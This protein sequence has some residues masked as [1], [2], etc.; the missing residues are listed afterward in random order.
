MIEQ[1]TPETFTNISRLDAAHLQAHEAKKG[2]RASSERYAAQR[3][4]DIAIDALCA[5]KRQACEAFAAERG[6][7]IDSKKLFTIEMLQTARKERCYNRDHRGD[8]HNYEIDHAEYFRSGR[9]PVAIL[10]HSYAP[11]ETLVA[12]AEK[13]SLAIERLP[14]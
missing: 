12:F 14:D 8:P 5:A 11:W 13:H 10:T 6:W 4:Y 2:A 9:I 7:V 3:A 1:S